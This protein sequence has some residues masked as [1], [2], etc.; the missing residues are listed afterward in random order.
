[1][2]EKPLRKPVQIT[3]TWMHVFDDVGVRWMILM[4]IGKTCVHPFRK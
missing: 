4:D 1:M 2:R 3:R